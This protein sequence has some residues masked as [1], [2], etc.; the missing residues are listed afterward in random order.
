L[1]KRV[2]ILSAF[3]L[4][5][6]SMT[7]AIADVPIQE[8]SI[9]QYLIDYVDSVETNRIPFIVDRQGKKWFEENTQA[10]LKQVGD[11]PIWGVNPGRTNAL[12]AINELD[13]NSL[14]IN[15]TYQIPRLPNSDVAD[16]NEEANHSEIT[17]ADVLHAD[18]YNGAGT[19]VAILDTGIQSSHEY[20]K[21]DQGNSRIVAQACFV[22]ASGESEWATR[23]TCSGLGS[24]K[25]KFK[26]TRRHC[27]GCRHCC[28]SRIW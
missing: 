9:D 17:G 2:A 15:N 24:W 23:H 1:S 20:F 22:W 19:S 3:A 21:D 7:P 12:F 5:L 14:L 18:G 4:S 27:A 25:W 8:N 28:S 6:A 11:L 26:C 16:T 13:D 10:V